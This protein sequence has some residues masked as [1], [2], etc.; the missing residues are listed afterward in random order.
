[1]TSSIRSCGSP[2]RSPSHKRTGSRKD[3]SHWPVNSK[4]PLRLSPNSRS[5]S[6][7][8]SRVKRSQRTRPPIQ[9][10]QRR[11][12]ESSPQSVVL[13]GDSGGPG[14]MPGPLSKEI[15]L[16]SMSRPSTSPESSSL[17]LRP[18]LPVYAFLGLWFAPIAEIRPHHPGEG[19]RA[20]LPIR[21]VQAREF[22]RR[23]GLHP[24]VVGLMGRGELQVHER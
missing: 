14:A 23:L 21:G 6:R 17:S 16:C 2:A 4:I 19:V 12:R 15:M 11:Q 24:N 8:L 20:V 3:G 5:A 13:L 7:M 22:P 9:T 10:G 18:P 1:M